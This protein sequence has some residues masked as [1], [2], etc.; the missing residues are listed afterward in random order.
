M[1]FVKCGGELGLYS[2]QFMGKIVRI[3]EHGPTSA[4]C[5]WHCWDCGELQ[6][7]AS[8]NIKEL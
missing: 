2:C 7:R 3:G 6:L 1:L 5:T 8:E 4:V